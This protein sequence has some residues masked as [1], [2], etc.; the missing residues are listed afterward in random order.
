LTARF[1][2]ARRAWLVQ[3]KESPPFPGLVSAKSTIGAYAEDF[4]GQ[5]YQRCFIAGLLALDEYYGLLVGGEVHGG[6]SRS[7]CWRQDMMVTVF[8][9]VEA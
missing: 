8:S 7:L 1:T 2:T 3:R 9:P 5:V 6:W 4:L